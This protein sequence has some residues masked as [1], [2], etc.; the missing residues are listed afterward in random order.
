[1]SMGIFANSGVSIGIAGTLITLVFLVAGLLLPG[2][3]LLKRKA[4][5][6]ADRPK[7]SWKLSFGW[8]TLLILMGGANI[9]FAIFVP[10]T[11]HLFYTTQAPP[12]Y[13]MGDALFSGASWQQIMSL[14]PAL[15]LWIVL[16][17]DNMCAG[18]M[19][20]GILASAIVV[21]G[22]RYARRWTYYALLPAT[23][24]V[25]IP[26]YL[27][28]IPSYQAGITAS[29]A[30]SPGLPPDAGFFFFLILL[31]VTVL[32]LLVPIAHFRSSKT[33]EGFSPAGNDP[34]H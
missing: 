24:L 14:S 27:I 9:F 19:G 25:F 5:S 8:I 32:G 28:A 21:K 15:G 7:G 11:D 20:G 30:I 22:F 31:V 1:M 26:S 29:G 33:S 6:S 2:T 10:L 18:M 23:A 4:V 13:M 3:E 16:Q 17:M 12:T 34:S